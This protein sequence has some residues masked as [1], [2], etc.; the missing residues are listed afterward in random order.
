MRPEGGW[1]SPRPAGGH[2]G[3]GSDKI[4]GRIGMGGPRGTGEDGL[5]GPAV[6]G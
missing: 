3:V 5:E 2:E 6:Q 1:D 4:K